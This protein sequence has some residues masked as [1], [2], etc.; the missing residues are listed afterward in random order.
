V[1]PQL[2]GEF[3][4]IFSGLYATQLDGTPVTGIGLTPDVPVERTR[5]GVAA[6]Q[7][8]ILRA[9]YE[10]LTGQPADQIDATPIDVEALLPDATLLPADYSQFA[11]DGWEQVSEDP[12]I[13][14]DGQSSLAIIPA[15]SRGQVDAVLQQ[16]FGGLPPAAETREI[17]ALTWEI[18]ELEVPQIAAIIAIAETDAL[19]VALGLVTQ[20][21]EIDALYDSVL[22]PALEATRIETE[23]Q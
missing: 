14:S 22:L 15:P 9:A 2:A 11:P 6:G 21:G 13:Y 18:I 1:T 4:F 10:A 16:N 20:T 12:V 5:A 3:S 17:G 7:D 8:E 23:A 19:T